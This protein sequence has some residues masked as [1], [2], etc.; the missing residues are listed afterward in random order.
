ELGYVEV[1]S[2]G[3]DFVRFDS[4][5]QQTTAVGAFGFQDPRLLG[6]LAGKD[7][8][9]FGTPFDLTALQNTTAVRNGTV[10]LAAVTH[11]RIVDVVGAADYPAVGD[12]YPDAFGRQILDAHKTVGSGGFDLA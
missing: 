4:A 2:N 5:S 9:G 6:G 1:S 3:T 12:T 7:P 10:D 8:A 11:V